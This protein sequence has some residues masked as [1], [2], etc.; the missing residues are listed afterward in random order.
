MHFYSHAI[1]IAPEEDIQ[2]HLRG[3]Y[4][5]GLTDVQVTKA[6]KQH[7]DTNRYGLRYVSY[8]FDL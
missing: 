4:E 1:H 6:L 7:Y 2:E 8:S 5:L 3:Y